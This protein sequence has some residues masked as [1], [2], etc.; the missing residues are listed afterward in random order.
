[1]DPGNAL[2]GHRL[3]LRI[4]FSA[5]NSFAWIF[6]FEYFYIIWGS[7]ALAIARTVLLYAL[8]QTVTCLLTPLTARGLRHGMRREMIYG[9]S[10][11]AAA[12]ILLGAIFEGYFDPYYKAAMIGFALL[13]GAYRALYWVPYEVERSETRAAPAGAYSEVL[14]ALMPAFAGFVLAFAGIYEAG[15]LFAAGVVIALSLIPL[16][17]VPEAY[18]HFPWGYRETFGILFARA[19]RRLFWGAVI[20]GIQGMALLLLWPLAVF[21]LVGWS[22][23]LFG[24]IFSFSFLL[25]IVARDWIGRTMRRM[26]IHESLPVSIAIVSSAWIGRMLVVNPLSVVVVDSYGHIGNPKI[27]TDHPAFE[28]VSDAGHFI[29]EYT[30]LRE[31]GLTLGRIALCIGVVALLGIFALPFVFGAAFVIAGIAAGLSVMLS[32]TLRPSI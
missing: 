28:Q 3:L 26:R 2:R 24:L 15:L 22:Y 18:E 1:M 25:L 7:L 23:P 27:S 12:F 30:A 32:R 10:A 21:F 19:H 8:S 16:V 4:A 31:I 20:D 29:D 14:I 11:A 17:S 13:I 9:A 6:V 5:A